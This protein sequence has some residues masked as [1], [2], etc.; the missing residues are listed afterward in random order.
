MKLAELSIYTRIWSLPSPSDHAALI[1]NA[2][3][4][5]KAATI[6]PTLSNYHKVAKSKR[7]GLVI[8]SEL[9]LVRAEQHT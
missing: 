3:L 9:A 8:S 6:D 7:E 1:E 4:V 5:D 2:G